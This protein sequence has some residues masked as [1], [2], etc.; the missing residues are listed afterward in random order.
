MVPRQAI[1]PDESGEPHVYRVK[2]DEADFVPVAL[3]V[4][5]T[6]KAEVLSG[7]NEGEVV[8]VQGGY[9]LPEKAKVHVKE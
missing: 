4:Q 8:I 3:G 9:G 2:G 6:D 1:Y 7:V 5:T